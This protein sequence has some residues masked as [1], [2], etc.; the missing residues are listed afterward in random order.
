MSKSVLPPVFTPML[1]SS[2]PVPFDSTDFL[3][4]LK[5]DGVRVL[6]FCE[7]GTTRLYSRTQRDVTHQYPEFADMHERL[8]VSSAVIDGEIV[9]PEEEGR[10][11]FQLLQQ[12]IGLVRPADVR[13]A[14]VEVP[15]QFVCFDLVFFDGQWI[16]DDPLTDRLTQL[17][18]GVDFSGRVMNSAPIE[19]SGVALFEAAKASGLE[20]VVAKRKISPYLVGRRSKDWLKIKVVRQMDCVIGGWSQGTGS[21]AS[22]FGSL[23]LGVYDRD[24]NLRYIGS[25]G[26]GFDDRSLTALRKGLETIEVTACPFEPSSLRAP[27]IPKWIR[28]PVPGARWVEP[29]LVCVVE[30]RELTKDF[31]LRAPSFKRL[32]ADKAAT[33]CRIE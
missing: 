30:Y 17:E 4:D 31:R 20:G 22:T 13:K 19:E 25:V 9:A 16:S 23:L 11:S 18:R 1:A 29:K 10:P 27:D 21:R 8:D 7:E 6:V 15:V 5:W 12:R 33:E 26:T 28:S 14:M 3:F 2:A 32:R 24:D